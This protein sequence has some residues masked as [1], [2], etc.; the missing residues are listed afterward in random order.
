MGSPLRLFLIISLV[1]RA[2]SAQFQPPGITPSA[3]DSLLRAGITAYIDGRYP[4]AVVSLK[5]VTDSSAQAAYYLGA[6]YVALGDNQAAAKVLKRCVG[7]SPSQSAYRVQLARVL[8]QVGKPE[9]AE[10]EYRQVLAVDSVNVASLTG[11]GGLLID[12]HAYRD[13]AA[14]LTRAAALNPRNAI[15]Y[16]QLATAMIHFAMPDSARTLLSTSITLNNGY[17]P[18]LA[19]LGSLYFDKKEYDDALRMYSAAA[20]RNRFAPDLWC[21]VGLC[22]EKLS[23]FAAAR[24]AY[25]KAV[26]LD[27]AFDFAY[28]HLGQVCYKLGMIDSAIIAYQRAVTLDDQIPSYHINLGIAWTQKDSVDQAVRSYRSAVRAYHPES[29][30]QVYERIGGLRFSKKQFREARE[31]YLKALQFDPSSGTIPLN[32]ALTCDHLKQYKA[33]VTWYKKFLHTAAGDPG[34]DT[35]V[36]ETKARLKVL[37]PKVASA[38]ED[39]KK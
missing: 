14:M 32:L 12:Q 16:Y 11:L 17:V 20:E 1:V 30:G 28:A 29:V 21:K 10:A 4:D 31:S 24:K 18:A 15:L 7:L 35:Q 9:D 6:T 5:G 3:T 26:E 25:L 36:R 37:E 38:K 39:G 8:V 33:A 27:T 2:A 13:G 22:Q 23:G 34:M 19:L